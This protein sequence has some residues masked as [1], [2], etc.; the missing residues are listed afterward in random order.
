MKL[1][2]VIPTRERAEYLQ[3]SLRS[4]F[5]AADLAQVPIE[6]VVSDNASTDATQQVLAAITDPRLVVQRSE[7]R[8][9]MRENFEFSLSRTSGSHI[10]FIGDDDAVLP[11]GLRILAQVIRQHDPDIVKWRVPSYLWSD[12]ATGGPSLL[13]VRPH[14][15]T[16]RIKTLDPHTVLDEFAQANARTYHKGGMIYHGCISRRLIEAAVAAADGPYF[17]GSSPDV[18]TSLRA[19]MVSDRPMIHLALPITLGGASPRSNGAAGK[20]N[21]TSG[22]VLQGTEYALFIAESADDEWQ[23]RLPSSCQSLNMVTLDCL[24][25]AAKL[26]RPDLKIDL[27]KW[28]QRI[29][30]EVSQFAE[31]ARST[32]LA[33]AKEVLGLTLQLSETVQTHTLT[34]TKKT[35]KLDRADL[36]GNAPTRLQHSLTRLAY[37]GGEHI[38]DSAAAAAFLDAFA[39]MDREGGVHS[40]S[41]ISLMN[42]ARMHLGAAR[43]LR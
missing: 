20:K 21:A 15:L 32:C 40:S 43:T 2:L 39:C 38:V 7:R 11:N 23:C 34:K 26:H 30:K 5:V 12:P 14:L 19:L 29:A 10:I 31:P 36:H 18:F 1:S 27:E 35:K 42:F 22:G 24:Q 13:K 6:I 8:L 37:T 33:Q 9:S 4:A 17:R 3:A 28:S 16:G 41:L 25:H